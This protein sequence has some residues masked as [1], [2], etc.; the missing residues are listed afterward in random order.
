MNLFLYPAAGRAENPEKI[1]IISER[2]KIPFFPHSNIDEVSDEIFLLEFHEKTIKLSRVFDGRKNYVDTGFLSGEMRHRFKTF[3]RK[4]S[5]AKA[6]GFSGNNKDEIITV[7][8]ATGGYGRDAACLAYIG[9]EVTVCERNPAMYLLLE[10]AIKEAEKENLFKGKLIP[11]FGDSSE[12]LKELGRKPE[13]IY[14][15]PMYP[16]RRKKSLSKK[17]MQVLQSLAGSDPDR[18]KL[19]YIA[20]EHAGKRVVLKRPPDI[21]PLCEEKLQMT[22]KDKIACFDIYMVRGMIPQT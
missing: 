1:K 8:D 17:N 13:V 3:S 15:D 7:F 2:Y 9:A 6:V 4:Q 14:L 19:F 21:L 18:E 10:E 20:L 11:V 22:F 16:Q 12:C 5:L